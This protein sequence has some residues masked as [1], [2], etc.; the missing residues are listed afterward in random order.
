VD[1][2]EGSSDKMEATDLEV[3]PKATEAIVDRQELRKRL[4]VRR[5]RWEEGRTQHSLGS[6]YKMASRKRLIHRAIP[7]VQKEHIHKGPRLV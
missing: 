2:F 1:T 6:R 4:V 5:C 3:N 7:S